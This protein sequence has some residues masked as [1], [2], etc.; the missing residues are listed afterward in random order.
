MGTKYPDSTL[1]SY[2]L[3]HDNLD[4]TD[5]PSFSLQCATSNC[6]A[7]QQGAEV[8]PLFKGL[9]PVIISLKVN[10]R[11]ENRGSVRFPFAS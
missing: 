4:V 1:S 3:F 10:D 6:V 7:S 5:F 9:L 8:N 2:D 11:P